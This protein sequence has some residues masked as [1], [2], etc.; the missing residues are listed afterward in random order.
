MYASTTGRSAC[1]YDSQCEGEDCACEERAQDRWD[2]AR[3]EA[4]EA[5]R[6]ERLLDGPD[7]DVW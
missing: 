7:G 5:A 1:D 4:A 6:E 3:E 2:D